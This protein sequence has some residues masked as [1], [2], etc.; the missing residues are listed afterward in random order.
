VKAQ[1]GTLKVPLDWNN[2]TDS[3]C[4]SIEIFVKKVYL[5]S[6]PPLA[7]ASKHLWM[8]PGGAGLPGSVNEPIAAG[9]V[10]AMNGSI[11]VYLVD[12]R[13]TGKSDFLGCP[14]PLSNFGGCIDWAKKPE[15]A[16]RIRA[17]TVTNSVKD[18]IHAMRTVQQ[19]E[20]EK[21]Q[22]LNDSFFCVL[23]A[24][25]VNFWDLDHYSGYGN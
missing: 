24:S 17:Q 6:D 3:Y 16:K 8:L 4:S 5:T 14:L 19:G 18:I 7:K 13:G 12:R 20:Q 2:S 22:S 25:Y 9:I 15:T 21:V 10:Q 1:C 11:E 23:P